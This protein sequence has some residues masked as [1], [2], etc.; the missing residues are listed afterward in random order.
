MI[1]PLAQVLVSWLIVME[2]GKDMHVSAMSNN[3]YYQNI[4]NYL[5]D[6]CL[7]KFIFSGYKGSGFSCAD[8]ST[9]TNADDVPD[10]VDILWF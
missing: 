5:L 6:N 7:H 8:E 10:L 2:I 3:H 4:I 9:L 1:M